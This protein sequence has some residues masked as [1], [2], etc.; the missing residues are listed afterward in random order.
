MFR[1]LIFLFITMVITACH[2]N[3]PPVDKK[4]L[5]NPLVSGPL[6]YH[7]GINGFEWDF[8][9][10]DN[11]VIDPGRMEVIRSFGGF[12]QYL[13][14]DK[15]E[16][17]EG[18]FTFSPVHAGGWRLDMIYEACKSADVEMLPCLKNC[19][20][21]LVDTYPENLKGE[22]NSPLPYLADKLNPASYIQQARAA[23]QFA[24]RYGHNKQVDPLL[25]R[26]DSHPRWTGDLVNEVK[27][28][29]GY[30]NYIECNNEPDKNWRG[31]KARQSAEEYAA[32]MSA[33]YDGNLGKLGKDVGIKAADPSM[34]VVMGGLSVSG[35]D[36]VIKMI[37][38]C[39]KNRGYKSDGSINLCFDVINYHYYSNNHSGTTGVAPELSVAAK[40][41][42]EYT[43]MANQ[44][45]GG[46]EVWITEAGYDLNPGSPQ[47]AIAIGEKSALITQADWM[48]RS[49]LLYERNGIKR[50]FFYMLDDV[51]LN[52]P[53]QYSSSG[54]AVGAKRRPVAD[55][56]YQT[57]KLMGDF[58]FVKSLKADPVV[59]V[60]QLNERYIYVLYIPDQ[61]GRTS[62][63]ELDLGSAKNAKIY[64]LIPGS[65]EASL[66]TVKVVNGKLLLNV[67]ETPFFV[68]PG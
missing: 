37:E 66:E 38:W 13:D 32:N 63:Y 67:T 46:T 24:A 18:K 8:S 62:P 25:V 68:E 30:L 11:S 7:L 59:D 65:N 35:V 36:F 27:V 5:T 34:K 1:Q 58:H 54:F 53:I 60:Y 41:A 26:V 21:W 29:L 14:W 51:D 49:A 20:T 47:R 55:Y 4:D 22:D 16:P 61:T 12:R 23:F 57:K 56:F 6:K 40:K 3:Q 2:K 48:L 39:K 15:I 45:A 19:A 28:G 33:F 64:R 10:Q 17:R 52:N 43:T 50:T 31:D 42:N 44:H 9:G